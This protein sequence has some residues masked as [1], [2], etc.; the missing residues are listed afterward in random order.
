MSLTLKPHLP[1]M[2]SIK[3]YPDGDFSQEMELD[4]WARSFRPESPEDQSF[5]QKV[6]DSSKD[7][8]PLQPSLPTPK[9]PGSYS[10]DDSAYDSDSDTS[11]AQNEILDPFRKLCIT[12]NSNSPRYFGKSSGVSLLRS[13]IS[14]KSKASIGDSPRMDPEARAQRRN[15]F[16]NLRPVRIPFLIDYII[17]NLVLVGT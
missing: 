13:A 6:A 8:S 16:W 12:P 11:F 3:L 5:S 15:D 9:I 17:P 4:G 7:I 2:F 14:A 10:D 1:L